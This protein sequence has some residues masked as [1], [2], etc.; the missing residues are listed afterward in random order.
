MSINENDPKT[1]APPSAEDTATE[2]YPNETSDHKKSSKS[3]PQSRRT[4]RRKQTAQQKKKTQVPA[5]DEE[6]EAVEDEDEDEDDHSATV[7]SP[8]PSSITAV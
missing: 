3:R 1:D 6:W 5:L 8:L 2:T 4:R 7:R